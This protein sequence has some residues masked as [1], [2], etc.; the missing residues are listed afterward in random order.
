[1]AF[2]RAI[3]PPRMPSSGEAKSGRVREETRTALSSGGSNILRGSQILI[4]VDNSQDGKDHFRSSFSFSCATLIKGNLSFHVCKQGITCSLIETVL[5][6]SL[7]GLE[8]YV[9]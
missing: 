2:P 3:T 5:S 6:R 8:L 9:E 4:L 7:A 1:M